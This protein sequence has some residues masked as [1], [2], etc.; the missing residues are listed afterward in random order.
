MFNWPSLKGVIQLKLSKGFGSSA[1]ML[2]ILITATPLHPWSSWPT[3]TSFLLRKPPL[4]STSALSVWHLWNLLQSRK[5]EACLPRE[6]SHLKLGSDGRQTVVKQSA[7]KCCICWA[8]LNSGIETFS[9]QLLC[10]RN[11]L[12]LH[13]VR[14]EMHITFL[15]D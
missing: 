12:H 2:Y 4:S 6:W 8:A 11:P 1:H 15:L 9:P 10:L 13:R 3:P 7:L 14:I 5:K